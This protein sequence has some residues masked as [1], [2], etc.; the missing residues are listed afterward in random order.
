MNRI[1]LVCGAAA[2]A[3]T[4]SACATVTRGTSQKFNIET[5]PDKAEVKLSSGE[6]CVSPCQLKLKRRPG[7]TATIKKDGYQTQTLTVESKIGGGG[8]VAG[9]GNIIL[10]GVIG[11][12]VDGTNGSM[13]SLTPNPLKVTL[14]PVEAEPAVAVA[15]AAEPSAEP[16]AAEPAPTAEAEPVAAPAPGA[17]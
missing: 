1:L 9:A 12:I 5:T 13:N 10:G 16:A 7:F 4:L 17:E 11:G 8:A 6:Q 2:A 3:L 15:P 14:L